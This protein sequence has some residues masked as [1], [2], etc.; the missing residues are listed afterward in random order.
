[1]TQ[2]AL[3]RSEGTW[4]AT[5]LLDGTAQT[6]PEPVS[7]VDLTGAT[8]LDGAQP[9]EE[10]QE[11]EAGTPL[12]SAPGAARRG[13]AA[14]AG[15]GHPPGPVNLLELFKDSSRIFPALDEGA[16]CLRSSTTLSQAAQ[17]C[18]NVVPRIAW[19]R[20]AR[21]GSHSLRLCPAE[22]A[23]TLWEDLQCLE[24]LVAQIPNESA[25]RLERK[26]WQLRAHYVQQLAGPKP[27]WSKTL[28]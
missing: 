16:L 10:L 11:R 19:P 5:G 1:M 6:E 17:G 4:R 12:N 23:N 13:S 2:S 26:V 27:H 24:P 15:E 22:N 14:R 7:P 25:I 28:H 3:A 9:E 8:I 20:A 18:T 21:S